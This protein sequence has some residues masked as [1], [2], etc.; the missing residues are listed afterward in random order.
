MAA[1]LHLTVTT[2]DNRRSVRR[3]LF[4]THNAPRFAGDTAGSFILR[5][6]IALRDQGVLV[7]IIAPATALL[8]GSDI[9]EGIAL[10]RV[11]Y[12]GRQQMTLAYSGTMAEEVRG[13]LGGKIAFIGL[14]LQLRARIRTRVHA[15]IR[16]G[17]PYDV[18]HAHWWFPAGV[19]A[20]LAG[21]GAS[22]HVPLL[23]TMHGS[24]VRLARGVPVAQILMRRVLRRARVVTAVSR[25]L[26]DTALQIVPTATIEVGPMPVDTAVFIPPA[27]NANRAG[28]LFVGRLNQQK[29]VADLLNAFAEINDTTTTLAI[30]GDGPDELALKTQAISLGIDNRVTWYGALKQP[31]L[32]PL[33]QRARVVAMPSREEGLGLVA[34]EAQLCSTPVVAYASGGLVDVV[35]AKTGGTLVQPGDILA[36]TAALEKMAAVTESARELAEQL[37]SAAR[38]AMLNSFS[39]GAVAARYC[40]LY[41]TALAARK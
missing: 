3:V 26:A 25:W 21:A 19:S 38:L 7:D 39:P 29:G 8:R 6:A 18:V 35:S 28:I 1:A 27:P 24:D 14:L 36:L 11:V 12:A 13:S 30:V 31:E 22:L 5:L 40:A 10:D 41:Q 32:I 33:Y 17:H 37:G 2:A 23:V 16:D 15:A 34:V 20:W 9:V 4:V